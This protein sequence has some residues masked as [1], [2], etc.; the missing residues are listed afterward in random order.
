MHCKLLTKDLLQRRFHAKFYRDVLAMVRQ[1]A[2]DRPQ[3]SRKP[4]LV[5]FGRWING[6]I[7]KSFRKAGNDAV[8]DPAVRAR[9][10]AHLVHTMEGAFGSASTTPAPTVSSSTAPTPVNAVD[11]DFI[12]SLERRQSAEAE[13]RGSLQHRARG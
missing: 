5:S 4:S 3:G 9:A 7:K 8:K 1:S 2:G 11:V 12:R 6:E 10:I 13:Q